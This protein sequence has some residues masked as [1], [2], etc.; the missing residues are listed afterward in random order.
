M[1]PIWLVRNVF[2][3]WRYRETVGDAVNRLR[4]IYDAKLPRRVRVTE[5]ILGFRY[6]P[7]VGPVTFLVE[8][9]ADQTHLYLGRYPSTNTIM[10]TS[11]FRHLRS[12][13]WEQTLALLR[14]ISPALI[15]MR[16]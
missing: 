15:Q 16:V 7:P 5:Q 10:S 12:L 13:I 2:N 14:S 4:W 8:Q 11:R 9:M 1:N 3:S 6:P